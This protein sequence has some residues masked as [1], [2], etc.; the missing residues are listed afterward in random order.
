MS[1]LRTHL[2]Y[3]WRYVTSDKKQRI[4]K[5]DDGNEDLENCLNVWIIFGEWK[6]KVAL[7]NVENPYVIVES[8]STWKVTQI[9]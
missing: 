8:I 1:T 6:G 3:G 5:F 9:K 2:G 7:Y 4:I